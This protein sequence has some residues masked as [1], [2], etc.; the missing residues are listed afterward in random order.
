MGMEKKTLLSEDWLSLCLGLF[1]FVLSLGLFFGL[2]LPG[3]GVKTNVWMNISESISSISKTFEGMPGL[4][5]I[6]L[7][8]LFMMFMVGAGLKLISVKFQ[9]L[10]IP[11]TVN[12]FIS[13]LCWLPENYG[14]IA[15]ASD[16]LE[17]CNQH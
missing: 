4:V 11:F 17:Q 9:D 1:V 13:Y 14:F 15:A 12:F 5:S 6:P 3:C 7:T 10:L 2:D 8:S 16:K